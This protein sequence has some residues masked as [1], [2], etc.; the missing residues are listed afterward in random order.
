M[1]NHLAGVLE[2]LKQNTVKM[3][4]DKAYVPFITIKRKS[5]ASKE[6]HCIQKISC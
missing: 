5:Q 6:I 1:R 4:S 2:N 3:S